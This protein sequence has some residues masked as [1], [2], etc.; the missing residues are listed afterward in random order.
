MI[1]HGW[2]LTST[3]LYVEGWKNCPSKNIKYYKNSFNSNIIIASMIGSKC[4][5]LIII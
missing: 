2:S 5:S 4:V 3:S 1:I